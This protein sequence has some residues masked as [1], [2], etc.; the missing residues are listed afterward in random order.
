MS[1]Q[2]R[3]WRLLRLRGHERDMAALAM[4]RAQE[5]A[6]EAEAAAEAARERR[7]EA[8][9]RLAAAAAGPQS[10]HDFLQGRFEVIERLDQERL[11]DLQAR[12]MHRA[13]GLRRGDL[14][15]AMVREEQIRHLDQDERRRQQ[16][17]EL[18]T[19]QK[20]LDDLR[21]EEADRPW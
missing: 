7:D 13:L 18:Q 1:R 4:R 17:A 5:Q 12:R 15:R 16:A 2:E 11:Q 6:L 14:R 3:L 10:V 9:R 20:A 19:E 8:E 21:R